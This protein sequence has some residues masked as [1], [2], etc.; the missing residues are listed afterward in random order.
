MG[1]ANTTR[2]KAVCAL[3]WGS[4]DSYGPPGSDR[5]PSNCTTIVEI[6]HVRRRFAYWRIHDLLRPQF[7][8]INHRRALERIPVRDLAPVQDGRGCLEK[9]IQ[10]AQAAQQ[11][12]THSTG[13]IPFNSHNH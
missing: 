2:P 12:G 11:L 1:L 4:R 3:L 6:G 13:T 10:R 9:G 8:V 5:S 7:P